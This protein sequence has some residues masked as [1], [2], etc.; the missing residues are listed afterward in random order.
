MK[1][2]YQSSVK[3]VLGQMGSR[4][5]GLTIK[6]VEKSREKCGWN[7]LA[8]GKKKSV[9]Q[10]FLE[11]YKDFLVIILIASAIISGILG[12]AESAAVIVIV[13][14]MNANRADGKSRA[15]ASEPEKAFRTGGEGSQEWYGDTDSGKR[16]G[17]WRC[18][19]SGSRGLCS[20]RRTTDRERKS[21]DR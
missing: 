3:E 11:Q 10:I 18:D 20:G 19:P 8:E 2:I 13:I 21:E 15:V 1:E 7:E 14:T 5:E 12:D 4:E 16:T 17:S 9:L 6:E